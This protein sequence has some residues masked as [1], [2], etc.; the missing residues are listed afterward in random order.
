MFSLVKNEDPDGGKIDV[1]SISADRQEDRQEDSIADRQA[2]YGAD[3]QPDRHANFG[4]AENSRP[5]MEGSRFLKNRSLG[6]SVNF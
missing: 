3:R 5:T 2:N 4:G 1:H 6:T